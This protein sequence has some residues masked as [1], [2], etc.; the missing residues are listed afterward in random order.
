MFFFFFFRLHHSISKAASFPPAA[1]LISEAV[2]AKAAR[3]GEL[4]D[5]PCVHGIGVNGVNVLVSPIFLA[6]FNRLWERVV[7]VRVILCRGVIH[8]WVRA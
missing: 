3:R 6:I 2:E 4:R 8:R 5:W 7:A 1:S